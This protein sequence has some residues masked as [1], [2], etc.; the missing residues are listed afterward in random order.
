MRRGD[1]R[2]GV[3]KPKFRWAEDGEA[4]GSGVGDDVVKVLMQVGAVKCEFCQ[5]QSHR[6]GESD[7]HE[8]TVLD[9]IVGAR[10]TSPIRYEESCGDDCDGLGEDGDRE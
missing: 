10:A 8:T 3:E 9:P 1:H 4:R 5:E 2:K 6:R 7:Q